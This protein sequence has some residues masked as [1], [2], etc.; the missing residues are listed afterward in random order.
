LS[1]KIGLSVDLR[2]YAAAS[3]RP[4]DRVRMAVNVVESDG[5]RIALDGTHGVGRHGMTGGWI[6]DGLQRPRRVSL[7]GAICLVFQPPEAT[8]VEA[9]VAEAL[10]MPEDWVA[11]LADGFVGEINVAH[12]VHKSRARYEVGLRAGHLLFGEVTIEC[13]ECGTRRYR[14]DDRCSA[15]R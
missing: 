6:A 10:E 9:G 1:P 4:L 3:M 13:A 2:P 14:R 5:K 12:L 7:L 11:G 8:V 15:C